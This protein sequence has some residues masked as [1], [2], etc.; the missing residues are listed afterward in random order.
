[1]ERTKNYIR[2]NVG[3]KYPQYGHK[4]HDQGSCPLALLVLHSL[5]IRQ[6]PMNT[7]D[8]EPTFA[9][10]PSQA[11]AEGV[12]RGRRGAEQVRDQGGAFLRVGE[13]AG[14][15]QPLDAPGNA[16]GLGAESVQQVF[17]G[18]QVCH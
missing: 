17:W 13:V 7:D 16:R 9:R 5:S 15:Q 4:H 3:E 18:H 14:Q 2:R 1:M 12:A 11:A 6:H 8:T 10:G